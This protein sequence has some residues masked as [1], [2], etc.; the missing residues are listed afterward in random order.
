V[1]EE[2]PLLTPKVGQRTHF[3]RSLDSCYIYGAWYAKNQDRNP[4]GRLR[5]GQAMA[6]AQQSASDNRGALSLSLE[7]SAGD[8]NQQLRHVPKVFPGY[9]ANSPNFDY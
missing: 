8:K 5:A 2:Y 1:C 4:K 6:M 9:R 3:F 7:V